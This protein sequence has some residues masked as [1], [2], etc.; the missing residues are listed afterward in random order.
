M[1]QATLPDK[2]LLDDLHAAGQ[3]AELVDADLAELVGDCYQQAGALLAE[4]ERLR[5][6]LRRAGHLLAARGP[7]AH[8]YAAHAGVIIENA[9]SKQGGEYD[10][11][12]D[13]AETGAEV[14]IAMRAGL[15]EQEGSK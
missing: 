9:L 10:P 7:S 8:I 11:A 12:D 1:A 13:L 5:E 2:V 4:N 3:R 14:Y 6:A 15:S